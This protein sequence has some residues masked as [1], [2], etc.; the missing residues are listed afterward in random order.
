[1]LSKSTADA[2]LIM[3][4]DFLVKDFPSLI[5]KVK[6]ALEVNDLIG[7]INKAKVLIQPAFF[8]CKRS[9]YEKSCKDFSAREGYDHCDFLTEDMIKRGMMVNPLQVLGLKDKKDF[10]HIGGVTQG[11]IWGLTRDDCR[12]KMDYVYLYYAL[13]M[14]VPMN[15]VYTDRVT[16]I[17]ALLKEKFPDI[18]P[19]THWLKEF[20]CE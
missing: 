3:H 10:F 4:P 5:Q 1:M 15:N 19:E 6:E 8:T 9:S 2:F 14:N 12:R 20:L 17:L 7:Y 18:N 13:K 11:Y 16:K